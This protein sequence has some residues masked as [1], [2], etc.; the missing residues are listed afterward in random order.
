MSRLWQ[1]LIERDFPL[2]L[3]SGDPSA[4]KTSIMHISPT[5]HTIQNPAAK[6]QPDEITEI[7]RYVTKDWKNES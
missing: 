1:R 5:L 3:G 2:R 4:S 7:V 6:L